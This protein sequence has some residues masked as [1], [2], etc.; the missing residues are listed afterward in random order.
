MRQA[1]LSPAERLSAIVEQG[2]CIGCGL[3]ESLAGPDTL[4]MAFDADGYERPVVVGALDHATVDLI[5]DTCPGVHVE[6]L[7]EGRI[8]AGTRIDA[9]WG[10]W[11]RIVRAWAADPELRFEG[12]TGGALSAL[13]SY[14]LSSR[15]VRF[16]LHAK[17]SRRAPGGGER[18]LS[19]TRAEVLEGIGSR[20]GPTAPLVDLR[21]LLDRGEPFAVIA[22]PCDLAALRN[23]ARHDPR[24]DRLVRYWLTMVCG[25][26]MSPPDLRGFLRSK[27]IEPEA[28]TGLRY[29]GRGCPGPTRVET[30]E[31]A[32]EFDYVDLWGEDEGDRGLPFRC[33]ICPDGLGEAADLCAADT[34]PGGS[35]RR[36]SSANDPGVNVLMA[37]SAAGQELIEAAGRD[38]ALCLAED[39]T[40]GEMSRCQPHQ[41]R[42]KYA[43]WPRLQG[44]GDEGRIVPRTARLRIRE[45]AAERPGSENAR[46]RDGARRRVREAGAA[47][48]ARDE[49]AAG[50]P[51]AERPGSE[52]ARERDGA[53]R[54]VRE[55]G[56]AGRARNEAAAGAAGPARDETAGSAGPARDEASRGAAPGGGGG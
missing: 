3:C 22:K 9:V 50:V 33:K 4:E 21:D 31:G 45:L 52:N 47:G 32:R 7:P 55:A 49:A 41:V 16:V 25:G 2:L 29:R 6:G 53:R 38:G 11:R 24:V 10:P 5:Y 35:P 17:A 26:F 13:A 34:W 28:V 37:R 42:R 30:A 44:L 39:G 15:R 23:Y 8:D 36:G 56:A 48:R 40:P 54:R 1:T 27:G 14:L 43:V 51:V 18:H 19:F 20:Y 12:A 46:E